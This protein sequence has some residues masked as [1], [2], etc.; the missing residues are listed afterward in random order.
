MITSENKNG[1]VQNKFYNK[2]DN[3]YT[4]KYDALFRDTLY[5]YIFRGNNGFIS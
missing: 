2:N 4:G 5:L 1:M 3:K